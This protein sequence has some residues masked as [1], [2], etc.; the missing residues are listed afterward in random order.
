MPFDVLNTKNLKM[1]GLYIFFHRPQISKKLEENVKRKSQ[2]MCHA[3]RFPF[4]TRYIDLQTG[5]GS[6]PSCCT[7]HQRFIE[8]R[9]PDSNPLNRNSDSFMQIN[10]SYISQFFY[11]SHI[12]RSVGVFLFWQRLPQSSHNFGIRRWVSPILSIPTYWLQPL[13]VCWRVVSFDIVS[14]DN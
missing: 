7:V 3:H 10:I 2:E 5:H 12:Q 14:G 8:I 11:S 1:A 13:L 6:I 4:S 9:L